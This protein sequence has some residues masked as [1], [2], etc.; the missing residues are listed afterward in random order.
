MTY[1]AVNLTRRCHSLISVIELDICYLRLLRS[2]YYFG[3]VA[4]PQNPG[5]NAFGRVLHA[6]NKTPR[7]RAAASMV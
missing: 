1:Q 4:M 7:S 3:F 6:T 5:I 2:F